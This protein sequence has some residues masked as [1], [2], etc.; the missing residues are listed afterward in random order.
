MLD[1]DATRP[2]RGSTT[3]IDDGGA[4]RPVAAHLTQEDT[5]TTTT[6]TTRRPLRR[7]LA[8]AVLPLLVTGLAACSSPTGGDDEASVEERARDWDR[9]L[10]QCARDAGF[11]LDDSGEGVAIDVGGGDPE[12]LGEAL[13]TCSDEVVAE[14]GE[15]PTTAHEEEQAAEFEKEWERIT[16]CFEEHGVHLDEGGSGDSGLSEAPDVPEDVVAACD[17]EAVFPTGTGE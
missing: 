13:D 17:A 2:R 16:S 7:A 8:L 9:A 6:T 1:A 4:D 5:V 10:S 11:D 14:L 3:D 12:A 15:R